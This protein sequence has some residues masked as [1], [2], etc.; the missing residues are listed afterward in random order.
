MV[1][2]RYGGQLGSL[3]RPNYMV[4]DVMRR[5]QSCVNECIVTK[6]QTLRLVPTS[7]CSHLKDS[8]TCLTL[9]DQIQDILGYR[10]SCRV[11]GA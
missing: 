5:K 4:S 6:D 9:V 2:G 7:Q 8:P 1:G 10:Q 3:H 11:L